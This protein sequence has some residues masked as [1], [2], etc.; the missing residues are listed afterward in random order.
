M[1]TVSLRRRVVAVAT[2]VLAALLLVVGIFVDADLGS[3]LRD[4]ARSRLAGLA[5]LGVQLDGTVDDQ[6]L[7]N[8]SPRRG[9]TPG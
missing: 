1:R 5:E 8:G 3:R 2:A 4:D 7:V 9:R 6:T